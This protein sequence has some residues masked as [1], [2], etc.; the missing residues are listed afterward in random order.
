[1]SSAFGR[2]GTKQIMDVKLHNC[3]GFSTLIF[4]DGVKSHDDVMA[5]PTQANMQASDPMHD[6]C[7]QCARVQTM[8]SARSRSYTGGRES[9][10]AESALGCPSQTGWISGWAARCLAESYLSALAL[11]Q[12]MLLLLMLVVA[13]WVGGAA[14]ALA[15]GVFA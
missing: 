14:A 1:M 10:Q 6:A 13:V 7:T 3:T 9:W 2:E 12:R 15:V 11:G 8:H 5:Q 4:T